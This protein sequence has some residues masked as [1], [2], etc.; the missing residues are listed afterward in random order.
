MSTNTSKHLSAALTD[1][2]S[3]YKLHQSEVDGLTSEWETVNK[4]LSEYHATGD[5]SHFQAGTILTISLSILLLLSVCIG[6]LASAKWGFV[7]SAIGIF[8]VPFATYARKIYVLAKK[9]NNAMDQLNALNTSVFPLNFP[10]YDPVSD[11]RAF[12][13]ESKIIGTLRLA[14]ELNV[15]QETIQLLVQE[16]STNK[17]LWETMYEYLDDYKKSITPPPVV[18]TLQDQ[19][20]QLVHG[21]RKTV[22]VEKSEPEPT[23]LNE[24]LVPKNIK[25]I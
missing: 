17:I 6:V 11:E 23:A 12:L 3:W 2:I 19:K 13:G 25:K 14:N 15:N 7:V 20:E 1:F 22:Q 21:F 5:L 18:R 10:S 9:H 8:A 4:P 24:V 16:K